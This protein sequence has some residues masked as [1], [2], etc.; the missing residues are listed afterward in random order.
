M[1]ARVAR[2][3]QPASPLFQVALDLPC[4]SGSYASPIL[5][6]RG[7][8][9]DV[10]PT[11][12]LTAIGEACRPSHWEL[13]ARKVSDALRLRPASQGS[14]KTISM[15]GDDPERR[16]VC[17]AKAVA[18]LAPH[19]AVSACF[20]SDRQTLGVGTEQ[21][22]RQIRRALHRTSRHRVACP[23]VFTSIRRF[24]FSSPTPPLWSMSRGTR[25]PSFHSF[26]VADAPQTDPTESRPGA[27]AMPRVW[28]R[29]G[30]D[31]FLSRRICKG[32][33]TSLPTLC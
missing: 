16:C 10:T 7:G 27:I 25:V 3:R 9:A 12:E 5:T 23:L 13:P 19:D 4:Q 6:N 11:S 17:E 26:P 2:T 28:R 31:L 33:G 21:S 18:R 8:S 20:G 29:R 22:A 14:G 24:C 15:H 30:G 32:E 1:S